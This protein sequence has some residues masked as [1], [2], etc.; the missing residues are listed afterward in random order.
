M[1]NHH[2][3]E[4]GPPCA[5]MENLLQQAADGSSK[6]LKRWYAVAHAARCHRCGTFLERL[7]M[8][9]KVVRQA[10]EADV[11]EDAMARLR[12]LVDDPAKRP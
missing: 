9:L 2:H 6:G 3:N 1:F 7:Q 5:H 12:A 4:D 10:K 8:T 11:D